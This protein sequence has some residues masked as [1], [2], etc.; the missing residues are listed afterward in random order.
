MFTVDQ[1]V[2][3]ARRIH[4]RAGQDEHGNGDQGE[5]GRAVVHVERDRHHTARALGRDQADHR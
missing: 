3:D 1:P 4:D 5:L 2:G